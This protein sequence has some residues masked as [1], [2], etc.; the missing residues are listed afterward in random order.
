MGQQ[1]A[2]A[3]VIG[4]L[5]STIAS[6]MADL[7]AGRIGAGDSRVARALSGRQDELLRKLPE[8]AVEVILAVTHRGREELVGEAADLI[9]HLLL[10]LHQQEVPFSEVL[11][12]LERRLPAANRG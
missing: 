3:D 12:E 9:F 5:E 7:A 11:A 10:V 2:A 8:E 4:E 1:A 6:R